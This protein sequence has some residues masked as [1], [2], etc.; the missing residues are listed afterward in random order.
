N[1]FNNGTLAVGVPLV[2]NGTNAVNVTVNGT[3][4]TS[5]SAANTF[6]SRL[7]VN[8]GTLLVDGSSSG[9]SQIVVNPGGNIGGTGQITVPITASSPGASVSPG[10]A[11]VAGKLTTTSI[12][13]N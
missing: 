7:D 5:F 11:G 10:D 2:N 9:G 8:S 4:V 13:S 1:I 12:F 3:G 6:T